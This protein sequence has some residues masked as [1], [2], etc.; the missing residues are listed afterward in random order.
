MS[1][2]HYLGETIEWKFTNEDEWRSYIKSRRRYPYNHLTMALLVVALPFAVFGFGYGTLTIVPIVLLGCLAVQVWRA[3]VDHKYRLTSVEVRLHPGLVMVVE[4]YGRPSL[5][6][7][8]RVEVHRVGSI[9]SVQWIQAG[10]YFALR[11]TSLRARSLLLPAA[12][13]KSAA[14][15]GALYA[16]AEHHGITIEGPAPIPGAYVRPME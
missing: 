4:H 5:L 3:W 16:W 8:R 14:E 13:F 12:L 11:S 1:G 15:V 10:C 6:R 2:G 7:D 9:K